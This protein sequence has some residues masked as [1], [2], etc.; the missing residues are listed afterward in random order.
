[1]DTGSRQHQLLRDEE[2]DD[3]VHGGT[4]P[5]TARSRLGCYCSGTVPWLYLHGDARHHGGRSPASSWF[6]VLDDRG[7]G[8]RC[9]ARW[10]ATRKTLCH[11]GLALSIA[12]GG[13]LETSDR[14]EACRGIENPR[15]P[16]AV[17]KA[18]RN[19]TPEEWRI[20]RRG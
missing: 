14:S 18:T 3:S 16:R 17:S 7:A 5:G 13:A 6:A 20:S 4:L 9:L 15:T 10:L 2:L 11:S 12:D 8:C 1:M 19:E